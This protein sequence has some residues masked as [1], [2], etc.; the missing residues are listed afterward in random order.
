VRELALSGH[1][2]FGAAAMPSMQPSTLTQ[3][4]QTQGVATVQLKELESPSVLPT[5]E[6]LDSEFGCEDEECAAAQ[7]KERG[8]SMNARFTPTQ[9]EFPTHLRAASPTGDAIEPSFHDPAVIR[10]SLG[11][12]V[13]RK[14]ARLL[15]IFCVGVCSTLAWQ[16]YGDEARGMIASSPQLGWLAPQAAPVVPKTSEAGAP[17]STASAEL[18]QLAFGL[19]ALRQSVDLLTTQ[20]TAS[21]QQMGA[22]IAKLRA[23]EQEILRKLSATA[24]RPTASPAQKPT[25]AAASAPPP[26]SPQPR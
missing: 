20:L 25:P 18:Q 14:L 4:A 26:P 16:S 15:V 10:S 23:D 13:L 17:A 1:F 22:A 6:A 5:L 7:R 3:Q 21:Q 8:A 12:R 2:P 9:L 19:A 24:P 11:R